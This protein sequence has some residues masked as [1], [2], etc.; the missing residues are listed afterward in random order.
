MPSDKPKFSVA[1][2]QINAG[3]DLRQN[4]DTAVEM[5]GK[6]VDEGAEL[7]LMPENV[8]MMEWGRKAITSKAQP[9]CDHQGL[10][11]FKVAAKQHSVWLHCGSLAVSLD[12]GRAANRT[13]VLDSDGEIMSRYDKIHMFDVDLGNGER[14]A[15]SSTFA[16]GDKAVVVDLPWGRLGLTI[17]YDLRFPTLFRDLAQGGADMIAV[18]S[19]FTQVTGGAHWHVLL[20]SRAIETGA[21][22]F[23]PA[24]TGTHPSDRKTYGHALIV[25]PWGQVL[26][27]AGA[28]P[29]IIK[30]DI[31]VAVVGKT[32][33]KMPS[34]GQ[35]RPFEPVSG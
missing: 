5:I 11:A 7:I 35:E 18:P 34:L 9:E 1:C 20:R 31:D 17:C 8:T 24:Q 28:G 6:A 14:Y 32:R 4:I 25:D 16:P 21:F 27:D 12:D 23:A 29:G 33:R 3:N 19:A 15:E 10:A 30:A 13:Y 26:A 2:L 22:I